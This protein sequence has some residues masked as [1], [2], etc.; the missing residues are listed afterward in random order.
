VSKC[1]IGYLKQKWHS[2]LHFLTQYE[3]YIVIK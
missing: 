2:I 3:E 1:S